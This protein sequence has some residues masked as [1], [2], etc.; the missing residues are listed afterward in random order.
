MVVIKTAR[1]NEYHIPPSDLESPP[2]LYLAWCREMRNTLKTNLPDEL[3]NP[4]VWAHAAFLCTALGNIPPED[5]IPWHFPFSFSALGRST[6][7]RFLVRGTTL[8]QIVF[9]CDICGLCPWSAVLRNLI[10][11][12]VYVR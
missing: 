4:T 8:Q 1:I 2:T 3:P 12:L 6:Q 7:Y 5:G 11:T 9:L 10:C